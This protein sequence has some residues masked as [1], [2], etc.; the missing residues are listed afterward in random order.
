MEQLW[1]HLFVKFPIQNAPS[2]IPWV[3]ITLL[4]N[5]NS[6]VN[7]LRVQFTNSI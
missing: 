4:E 1:D 7:D 3:V 5:I 2:C 6:N